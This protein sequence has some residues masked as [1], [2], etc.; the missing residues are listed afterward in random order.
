MTPDS[1]VVGIP[2]DIELMELVGPAEESGEPELWGFL[3][4]NQ[5]QL[6]SRIVDGWI[7]EQHRYVEVALHDGRRFLLRQ[8]AATSQWTA[9]AL[10]R[11]GSSP[12]RSRST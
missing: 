6:I 4:D 1:L 5:L 8:D 2:V 11:P 3:F 7:A 9:S 12:T 10:I